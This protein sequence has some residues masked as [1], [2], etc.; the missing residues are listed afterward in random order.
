MRL[1]LLLLDVNILVF[2]YVPKNVGFQAVILVTYGVAFHALV[3]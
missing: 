3:I 2:S 1:F